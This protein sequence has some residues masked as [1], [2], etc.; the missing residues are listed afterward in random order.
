MTK[1]RIIALR[2]RYE[3]ELLGSVA[4][5]W[6]RHGLDREAGG[7][8]CCLDRDGSVFDTDKFVWMQGRGLWGFSRL[9]RT[10]GKKD[11]WLE[12]AALGAD[13]LR[14]HGRAPN[15][16][17]YFALDRHGLPLVQPYNIFSDC[18]C[19]AAFAEYSQVTGEAWARELAVDGWRRIQ[20]RKADPKGVWTKQISSNRP[21]KAMAMPM[22]QT[23]LADE[24]R[25]LIPDADLDPI[26]DAS[27]RQVLDLHVDRKEGAIFE[28]VLPDGSHPDCMEGRLLNP[29]HALE[30]L[31][32]IMTVAERRGDRALIEDLAS[33]MLMVIERGWDDRFGGIF[34]YQDFR[35]L[36]TE[37][38]E[39]SMK[40]WWV[41]AEALCAFL[42][43][44]KL[45]G[46]EACAR[47][48]ERISEWTWSHFP[49]PEFG[50]WYGYLDR[51][52][53]VSLA[54]KGGKWKGF[55]HVPRTLLNCVQ[56]LKEMEPHADEKGYCVNWETMLLSARNRE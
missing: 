54:L 36:P 9:C 51:S 46:N 33:L 14:D 50:E 29:G 25:G 40:L 22:I 28:R 39:S 37:K 45:T 23:W 16:D 35:G 4:P 12:A 26:V 38:L 21:I 17:W 34:Y 13:F 10:Y 44:Y 56:W 20:E 55:F 6:E 19:A 42:L 41:H 11:A 49:D 7:Y 8:F 15:G 30:T 31:W 2:E 53:E 32:L 3:G 24:F 18:F 47:W 1:E 52:G 43:A 27:I 5:F 48:F